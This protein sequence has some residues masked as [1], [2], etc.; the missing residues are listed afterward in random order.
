MC[1]QQQL[2][3]KSATLQGTNLGFRSGEGSIWRSSLVPGASLEVSYRDVGLGRLV[4]R[5]AVDGEALHVSLQ[6]Q[7]V[8]WCELTVAQAA[9]GGPASIAEAGMTCSWSNHLYG[10]RDCWWVNCV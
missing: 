6:A 9:V 3:G 7:E 4:E 1:E 8:S 2:I 5:K 10:D